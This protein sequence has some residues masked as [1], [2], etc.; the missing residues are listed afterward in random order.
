[1]PS[2]S[3]RETA[4][5]LNGL[6]A[7]W[8]NDKEFVVYGCSCCVLA[9]SIA[10]SCF[11][12]GKNCVIIAGKTNDRWMIEVAIGRKCHRVGIESKRRRVQPE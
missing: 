5:A 6:K 11:W 8:S 4:K 2:E 3:A 1:M 7:Q 9:P 12:S 10:S